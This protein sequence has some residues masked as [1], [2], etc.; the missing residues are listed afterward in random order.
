VLAELIGED[1]VERW[2]GHVEPSRRDPCQ[3]ALRTTQ[4]G[5]RDYRLATR[6][7]RLDARAV[8]GRTAFPKT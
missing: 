2:L 4:C 1:D 5:R 3:L 7:R 8:A 6:P